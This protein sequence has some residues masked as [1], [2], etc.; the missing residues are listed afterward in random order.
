M[1]GDKKIAS[2]I[3]MLGSDKP[4]EILAAVSAIKR[5]LESQGRDFNDLGNDIETRSGALAEAEIDQI[6]TTGH[7]DGY[8]K[9]MDDVG[10]NHVFN[11][12]G[13]HA[14]NGSASGLTWQEMAQFIGSKAS[15]LH[16]DRE[17][18]FAE[19]IAEQAR[20]K[21]TISPAQDKWLRDLYVKLGGTFT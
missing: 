13:F 5:V 19:S 1:S 2:L 8:A 12:N 4:G 17:R 10:S 16:R 20:W 6:Y 18:E 15:Y 21:S 9:A 7:K 11:L 14:V 3:R